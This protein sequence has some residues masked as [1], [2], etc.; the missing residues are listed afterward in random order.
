MEDLKSIMNWISKEP[1][2]DTSR[3]GLF[4]R[5]FGGVIALL[6][7]AE[8]P[9]T[10]SAIV[11]QSPPFAFDL[12]SSGTPSHIKIEKGAF[13]F[14]KEKMS[15]A[16]VDQVKGLE[17]RAVMKRLHNIPLLHIGGGKD[18]VVPSEHAKKYE[19][20]RKGSKAPT[21]FKTFPN[22]DHILSD[23]ADRQTALKESSKWFITHLV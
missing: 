18:E 12:Y 4:G 17:M 5:S 13:F 19:S 21:L 16:F 10:I 1:C 9:K 3:L 8:N 14:Q 22:A 11:V 6:C 2:F 7:A 15:Q 23:I 20:A